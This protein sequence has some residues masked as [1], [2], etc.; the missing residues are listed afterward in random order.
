MRKFILPILLLHIAAVVNAAT[1]YFSSSSGND[2]RSTS[3]AQNSST[4]W[5]SISK[6]NS[7]MYLLQPGD[8]VL[9]KSGDTFDGI[10]T[11]I[12]VTVSG[13]SGNPIT[14]GSY[15]SGNKPVINGFSY[16][17]NWKQVRS[18]VWEAPFW[19]PNGMVRMVIKNNQQQGIGRYP[20]S[21]AD[22]GGYLNIDDNDG[23][24]QITS[25]SLP[26]SPNWTGADI[27]V[28][29]NHWTLDRTTIYSH[30]GNTLNFAAVDGNPMFGDNYGFFIVNNTNTLDQ[31]GEWYYDRSRSRLQ[32]YFS[33]NNPN[34]YNVQSS[35]VETLVS[36]SFQ[37]YITF[38]NLSFQGANSY[39][40]QLTNSNNITV[41]NCNVNFTGIDGVKALSSDYFTLSNSTIN[42]TNNDGI[43]LYWSCDYTTIQN[44]MITNTAIIPGMGQNAGNANQGMYVN[45][46]NNLIQYCEVDNSGSNGI[47]FDG[48]W[49]SI[50]N[51][52]VN[53]FGVTV[54]D[55]GG[56]Y[57]SNGNNVIFNN[58]SIL[59]NVVVNGIGAN[60]GTP[61]PTYIP[62][63]GIYFDN[64]TNHVTALRNTVANCAQTGFFNH[65]ATYSD[66][67]N[68]TFYNNGNEQF[69]GVRE[70]NPLSSVVFKNNICFSRTASQL[71]SRLESESGSNNLPQIGDFNN[72]YYCRPIDNNFM[73][74][75][76]D[77]IGNS[78]LYNTYYQTLDSWQSNLGLDAGS[79][80]SPATIS[81]FT[82]SN[83]SGSNL[84]P[85]GSFSSNIY[86]VAKWSPTGDMN[87][88]WI[89]NKLDGGTL[90]LSAKSYSPSNY[91]YATLSTD[92]SVT[93]GQGY[94][95][96]FTMQGVA[97]GRPMTVYL[98]Q[99][100]PPNNV[101]TQKV[102]VPVPSNRQDFQF[103]FIPTVSG[104]VSIE[105]DVAQPNGAVWIDNVV[106]QQATI[107]P[108]NPDDYIVFQYNPYKTVKTFTLS[109]TYMDAKGAT[110]SGTVTLQPYTSLVLFKPY[111]A[112]GSTNAIAQQSISL[113][114]NLVDATASSA[115]NSTATKLNWQVDNQS[116]AASY[117]E[118]QRSSD[119]Q[120]FT[121]IGKATVT[122]NNSTA[123]TYQYQ[124]ASPLAGKNYYRIT[125]RN[126]KDSVASTSKTV[127]VNNISF[128]VNPNPA[129]D[130]IHLS[131]DEMINT[132]DHLDKAVAIRNAAGVTVQTITLPSTDNLNR[133]DIN[134][135]GLQRGMYVVSVSS[136]GKSFSK[137]FIK[138]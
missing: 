137:K 43:N 129:K 50:Q 96:S 88:S 134:V 17:M 126:N 76:M 101:I 11:G 72:N 66:I 62:A 77:L 23:S 27:V 104:R 123:T 110:Y 84:F 102:I 69:L 21:D 100:D 3:Q 15:G 65:T 60:A 25:N 64:N 114:G 117:Y 132:A 10:Y 70:N 40:F 28:R 8:Q 56:I 90:Q 26:S 32:M 48:D 58:K 89:S 93:A 46:S 54:D 31:D 106:L 4:P 103:G 115:I 1:Y 61:D 45:G 49:S 63:V 20:N 74:Y 95:L 99:Q 36:I 19:Q 6:L 5:Q 79:Q 9:F 112:Q 119:A 91:F 55:C 33:D 97:S 68:N 52:Y 87:T 78:G 71:V 136:E 38:N 67:E 138:E 41:N 92:N 13:N 35:T 105:L 14:F 42:N 85:N 30:S 108:T 135:A 83:L 57:T 39:T 34:A 111:T 107:T 127:V 81:P 18:N 16:A 37:N 82:A 24:S 124:D 73:F 116:S 80:T 59:D 12:N 29:K 98:K 47:H 2:S 7:I 109:G 51:C 128:K 121:T 44:D 75:N 113:A 131:F 86:N 94:Q 118:V 122:A 125:Q 130:V 133:V 22:N 120:N 53:T